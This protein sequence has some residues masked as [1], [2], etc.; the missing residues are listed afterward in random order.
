MADVVRVLRDLA[1][2]GEPTPLR[3]GSMM[4]TIPKTAEAVRQAA[5]PQDDL[6]ELLG[7][8]G[9]RG[10]IRR[11]KAGLADVLVRWNNKI[12]F[13]RLGDEVEEV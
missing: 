9:S 6:G 12:R 8:I 5:G 11:S 2:E 10:G 4:R 7:F 3:A 1:F 13:L